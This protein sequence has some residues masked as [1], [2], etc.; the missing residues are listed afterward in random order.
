M[1]PPR[2]VPPR[3]PNRPSSRPAV[4]R[5]VVAATSGSAGGPWDEPTGEESVAPS[6]PKARP[7]TAAPSPL[8]P[9]SARALL[10]KKGLVLVGTS[11]VLDSE[12]AA[13]TKLGALRARG[14]E[15]N[16]ATAESA[17]AQWSLDRITEL[18]QAITM[19]N[20]TIAELKFRMDQFPATYFR[21]RWVHGMN[22][23]DE[24]TFQGLKAE[25]DGLVRNRDT[26]LVPE[27]DTRRRDQPLKKLK[28]SRER[29]KLKREA[30]L[31]ALS[32]LREAVVATSKVYD[33]LAEDGEVKRALATIGQSHLAP[34][35]EFVAAVRELRE[36]E[37]SAGFSTKTD[38][39][40]SASVGK[41]DRSER[42]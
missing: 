13:R 7:S 31:L 39:P 15:Y 36:F 33:D 3:P 8:D 38:M 20:A 16:A 18:D 11:F 22:M 17:A 42:R 1:P 21:G 6:P 27:R 9:P 25:R 10:E 19:T 5:P 14:K 12:S 37:K 26:S 34:S 30:A 4:P 2:P 35:P 28:E 41:A 40:R 29:L 23:G 32:D 24:A